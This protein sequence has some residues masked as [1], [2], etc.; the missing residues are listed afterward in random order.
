M[1]LDHVGIGGVPDHSI[2]PDEHPLA[3]CQ[4]YEGRDRVPFAELLRGCL[5]QESQ[6]SGVGEESGER[7]RR[8]ESG[9]E[10]GQ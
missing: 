6:E 9:E 8:E 5:E 4:L 10:S 3:H 2:A 1:L 7:S